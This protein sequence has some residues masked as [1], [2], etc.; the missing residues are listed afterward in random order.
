MFASLLVFGAYLY[1]GKAYLY[2][3]WPMIRRLRWFFLSILIIYLWMTPGRPLVDGV[4][5][6]WMPTWEGVSGGFY[7]VAVLVVLVLGVQLL[8]LFTE[9]SQL[10][11]AIYWLVFPLKVLG[12]S[13]ERLAVRM[14]LV[15]DVVAETQQLA[16]EA[17][18]RYSGP[19]SSGERPANIVVDLIRNVVARADEQALLKVELSLD[20]APPLWQ[21]SLPLSLLLMMLMLNSIALF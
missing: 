8:I 21:W 12:V 4:D 17:R 7:R 2:R 15:M 1:L 19:L 3:V 11:S 6:G 16:G 5:S 13:R 10:V 18:G 9:R 14:A 20:S